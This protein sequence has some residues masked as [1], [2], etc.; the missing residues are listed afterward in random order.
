MK[1]NP[2]KGYECPECGVFIPKGEL[3]KEAIW[4][5]CSECDEYYED[6]NEALECCKE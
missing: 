5:Q 1:P 2:V 6:R 4:Y 3:P